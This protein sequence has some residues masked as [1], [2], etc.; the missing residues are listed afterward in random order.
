MPPPLIDIEDEGQNNVSVASS[1]SIDCHSPDLKERN[2]LGL[3]ECSSAE[4]SRISS[5]S[6]DS[7]SNLNLK[8]TELRLGLPGS[9]SPERNPDL[10]F[11][12]S[13]K[14]DEKLLFPLIPLSQKGIV[15]GNKRGFSE[16]NKSVP[17][18]GN[19]IFHASENQVAGSGNPGINMKQS[20]GPAGPQTNTTNEILSKASNE[21][22]QVINQKNTANNAPAAK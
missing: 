3:S 6:E 12:S 8:A 11:L 16:V 20:L 7:K 21:H 18:E 5:L 10:H 22:S 14:L 4:S 13:G 2:Y 15:Y 19:W 9:Q 17:K 1:S